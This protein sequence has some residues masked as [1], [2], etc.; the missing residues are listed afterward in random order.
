VGDDRPRLSSVV[1]RADAEED[2]G[3]RYAELG[4]EHVRDVGVVVVAG[5]TIGGGAR[6]PHRLHVDQRWSRQARGAEL[7]G[8][9]VGCA[10]VPWHM[11]LGAAC[12]GA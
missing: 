12:P 7:Q 6:S 10:T 5:M 4:E 9:D 11:D 2:I 1:T 8:A 3:S